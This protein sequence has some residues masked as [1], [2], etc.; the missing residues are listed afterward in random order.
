VEQRASAISKRARSKSYV[1][2]RPDTA[3]LNAQEKKMRFSFFRDL[4]LAFHSLM[5]SK[6]PAA[7]VI[8]TLALGNRGQRGIFTLVR[9]RAA[10]AAGQ[11]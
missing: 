5:H 10:Q 11:P 7:I 8:L 1:K 9:G 4:R 2:W 6:K 3:S